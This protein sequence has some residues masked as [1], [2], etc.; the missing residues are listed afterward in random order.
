LT[1]DIAG[2]EATAHDEHGVIAALD[3]LRSIDKRKA[4]ALEMQALG[5][6]TYHEIADF[7]GVSEQTIKRELTAARALMTVWLDASA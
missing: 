3:R 6:A 4:D 5:G 1:A 7:L 2:I